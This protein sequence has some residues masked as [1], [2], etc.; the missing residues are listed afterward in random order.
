LR[1]STP[2][3]DDYTVT[4]EF[5]TVGLVP[6]RMVFGDDVA[7]FDEEF[8]GHGGSP[9]SLGQL[10]GDVYGFGRV[11]PVSSAQPSSNLP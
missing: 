1:Y 2:N 3:L 7:T 9:T 11:T 4:N 8:A 10:R 5:V 6:E